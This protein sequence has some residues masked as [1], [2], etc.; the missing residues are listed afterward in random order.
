MKQM[1]LFEDECIEGDLIVAGASIVVAIIG[2]YVYN[3]H[4]SKSSLKCISYGN[5]RWTCHCETEE[6]EHRDEDT[7]HAIEVHKLQ[8][9]TMEAKHKS[10]LAY[11]DGIIRS[12]NEIIR[13][14]RRQ[15][16]K[17]RTNPKFDWQSERNGDHHS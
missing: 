2:M 15:T 17:L 8:I 3:S 13:A 16:I 10:E 11:R 5:C 6:E 12:K 9:E 7:A 1:G 14:L 4:F